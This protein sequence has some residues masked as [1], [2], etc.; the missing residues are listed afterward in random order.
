[1]LID[2]KPVQKGAFDGNCGLPVTTA[3]ALCT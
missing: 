3:F 1:M 2:G